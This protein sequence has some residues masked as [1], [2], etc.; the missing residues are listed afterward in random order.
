MGRPILLICVS[1][2]QRRLKDSINYEFI[3]TLV[4]VEEIP[5][6]LGDHNGFDGWELDRSWDYAFR[7]YRTKALRRLRGREY[8]MRRRP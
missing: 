2:L 7:D 6:R 3:P 1:P 8:A 4:Q 5:R